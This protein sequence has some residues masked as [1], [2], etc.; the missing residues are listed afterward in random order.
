MNTLEAVERAR[1]AVAEVRSAQTSVAE[2]HAMRTAVEELESLIS[3]YEFVVNYGI[4]GSAS[5]DGLTA[6][7]RERRARHYV[8]VAMSPLTDDE[9]RAMKAASLRRREEGEK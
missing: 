7:E 2:Y 4:S 8:D 9:L 6:A 1:R 5:D 3:A